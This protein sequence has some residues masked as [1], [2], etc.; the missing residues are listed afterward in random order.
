MTGRD[1]DGAG[2]GATTRDA[3]PRRTTP[4]REEGTR[5]RGVIAWLRPVRRRVL[6]ALLLS[7]LGLNWY[8]GSKVGEPE[9]PAEV[10]YTAFRAEVKSGNVRS[11]STIGDEIEG[12]FRTP[13]R[14]PEGSGQRIRRFQTLRPTFDDSHLLALLERNEVEVQADRPEGR[15]VWQILALSFGPTLLLVALFVWLIRRTGAFREHD[16]RQLARDPLH[17]G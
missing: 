13:V 7:A 3:Q 2:A 16:A 9:Q 14:F 12:T 5:D 6:V 8:L 17:G 10:S 15:P 1:A 4:W 11:V